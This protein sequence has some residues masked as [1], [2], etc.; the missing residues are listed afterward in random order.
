MKESLAAVEG[1][2]VLSMERRFDHP[3]EKVWRAITDPREM[4]HWFPSLVE[5]DFRVG[6]AIRFFGDSRALDMEGRILELDPPW[7]FM[8]AWGDSTLRFELVPDE[9]GPDGS[10][11]AGCRM[12]FRHTFDDPVS[13]ASFAAG[14]TIC[15]QNLEQSLLGKPGDVGLESWASLH[16]RFVA[17][18]GLDGGAVAPPDEPGDDSVVRF[19][20]QLT[21]SVDDVWRVLTGTQPIEVGDPPPVPFTVGMP[22]TALADAPRVAVTEVSE[23]G[24]TRV[25][26]YTADLGAPVQVRWQLSPGNGG[27]RL[28]LTEIV[29]ATLDDEPRRAL[30]EW[31]DALD[32]LALRLRQDE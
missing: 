19:A 20:R 15:F 2:H 11:T 14:W 26:E 12:L 30:T 22:F 9:A 31:A 21:R 6:G 1:R 29:P 13:G 18:F 10:E 23:V 3:V 7:L 17:Q 32:A 25:L 8:Y 24:P 4:A 16:D 5:I 27:A 28:D